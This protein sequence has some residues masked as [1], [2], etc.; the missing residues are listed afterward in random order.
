LR[1]RHHHRYD[2]TT[3]A[4]PLVC[5]VSNATVLW[6]PLSAGSRRRLRNRHHSSD[7]RRDPALSGTHRTVAL[8]TLQ[9]RGIASPTQRFYGSHSVRDHVEDRKSGADSAS[10]DLASNGPRTPVGVP[11]VLV[12]AEGDG[13]EGSG[14]SEG[15]GQFGGG[16]D[17]GPIVKPRPGILLRRNMFGPA[18]LCG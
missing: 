14:G 13:G 11:G 16:A 4:I 3:H 9:T 8:E 17:G 5:N 7:L 1:N 6:V 2:R 15:S 18:W 12:L 10:I